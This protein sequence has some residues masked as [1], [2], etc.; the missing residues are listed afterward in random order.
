MALYWCKNPV[1]NWALILLILFSW[2]IR[3]EDKDK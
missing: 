2:E 1:M 3:K